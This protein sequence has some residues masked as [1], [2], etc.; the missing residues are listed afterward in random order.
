MRRRAEAIRPVV[1]ADPEA[2]LPLPHLHL[3]VMLALAESA[4]HGWDIVKRIREASGG[5]EHPS[6]GSLYLALNRLLEGGLLEEVDAPEGADER[7]RYVRH[8][9]LGRRVL[10]AETERLATLV[11]LSRRRLAAGDGSGS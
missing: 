7:R 6:S 1:N 4:L 11:E 5:R 10:S 8:T 2:F 3:Q 9:S